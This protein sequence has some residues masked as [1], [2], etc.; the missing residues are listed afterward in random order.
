M[1]LV[2]RKREKD[3][4]K[5]YFAS[6][7][8]E[9][10]VVYGRRRVGKT[11]LIRQ[12]FDDAFFFYATGVAPEQSVKPNLKANLE[13]FGKS[14]EQY[15]MPGEREPASWM[16]A[17]D[18]LAEGIARAGT[19]GR[20]VI[21]LDEM[22]W[23]DT[24]KSKF[25]SALEYFWNAFASARNDILL[26]ACGSAATWM[27]QKIFK[28]RG[29]LHNRITGK[30]LVRPFNLNECEAYF[31]MRDIVIDRKD[32]AQAYMIFGGIPYYLS[33]WDKRYG[34]PQNV[35]RIVFHEDAPLKYEFENLYASLF[36]NSE[37]YLEAIA[38]LSEKAKG[39]SRDEL[40]ASLSQKDGGAVSEMLSNLELSGFIRYYSLFPG[41]TNG[42]LYQLI[43]NFS[44]FHQ[45]FIKNNA[46]DNEH[47]WSDLHETPRMN[48]WRGYAFEQLCLRHTDQI[49]SALSI[50][51]VAADIYSWRSKVSKPGAQ[52]DLVI[53]R[54][55]RIVNLCEIKFAKYEF[56]IKNEYAEK[57]KNKLFAF[58]NETQTT[59][60]LH[61]TFVT[62]YGVKQNR[63]SNMVQSEV[64]LEALFAPDFRD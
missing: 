58:G 28:N 56:E 31:Q 55:D 29:G 50:G 43:D 32:I 17:F 20:K 5:R 16:E 35:D 30:I 52:V 2:G 57:L 7:E 19:S 47:F 49:R 60:T 40:V 34:L 1:S 44:L 26:I 38:A 63:Y 45:T 51:G 21:F 22:P 64:T 41:K 6:K 61:L 18:R 36:K 53:A 15:G 9:F 3:T 12:Y 54:A 33:Y 25:I 10:V 8:S 42:G 24:P 11:Y 37:Y 14:L 48:T 62:T 23:M 39:L 13:R 4:L 27:T 46:G 59:G